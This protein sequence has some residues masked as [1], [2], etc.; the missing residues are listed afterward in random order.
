[1]IGIWYAIVKYR[2]LSITPE[3]VSADIL[4]SIDESV[5]LMDNSLHFVFANARTEELASQSSRELTGR[6]IRTIVRDDGAVYEKIIALKKS[7]EGKTITHIQLISKNGEYIL[8]KTEIKMIVDKF[9]DESGYLAI[10]SEVKGL[11]HLKGQYHLTSRELEI[12]RNLI[13]GKSNREMAGGL[14]ITVNTLKRHIA[15]IY[16]KVDV[17]NRVQLI[18]FFKNH[19]IDM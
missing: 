9:K 15:N 10:A 7:G 17:N 6:H 14:K 19:G 4:S 5:F 11:N 1:M 13:E 8:M 12:I 2:F 3:T 18:A 16:M